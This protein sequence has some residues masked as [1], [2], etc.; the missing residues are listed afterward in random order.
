[1]V[2]RRLAQIGRSAG[3]GVTGDLIQV[4]TY[5]FVPLLGVMMLIMIDAMVPKR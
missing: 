2:G 3:L 1:M 5:M 4:L